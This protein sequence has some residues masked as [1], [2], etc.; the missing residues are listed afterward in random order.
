MPFSRFEKLA[1]EKREL[2]LD[3]A[4]R[5]FAAHG[6]EQSSINRILEQSNMSKGAAYYYFEDKADLFVTVI[7]YASE[8]LRLHELEL[9]LDSTTAKDFWERVL[10][11]HREPILRSYER[12][13]LFRVFGVCTQIP[14]S[15]MVREPLAS[16]IQRSKDQVTGLIQRGQELG[17]IRSDLPIDLLFEWLLAI[18]RA[19][20]RWLSQHWDGLDRTAIVQV[21][22]QTIAAIRSAFTP[23]I[24]K[25]EEES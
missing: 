8:Y 14:A 4:A 6:F 13:W 17:V 2:L 16:L 24:I 11:N 7:Q 3:Q 15:D 20:D 10:A 9:N 5:E 19:S 23:G 25:N 12:P 22:D 1:R 18:D 21:A